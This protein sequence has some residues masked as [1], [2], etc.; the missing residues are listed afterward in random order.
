[1][2]VALAEGPTVV[3]GEKGSCEGSPPGCGGQ[4]PVFPISTVFHTLSCIGSMLV[5]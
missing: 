2:I 1:M 3:I 5:S 4:K